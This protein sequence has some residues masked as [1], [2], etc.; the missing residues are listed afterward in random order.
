[1]LSFQEAIPEPASISTRS[2]ASTCGAEYLPGASVVPA[3]LCLWSL[4]RNSLA[5][6]PLQITFHLFCWT[7]WGLTLLLCPS[8]S[9]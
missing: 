6:A 3:S 7:K 5:P 1:M 8:A 2:I 9:L 4:E